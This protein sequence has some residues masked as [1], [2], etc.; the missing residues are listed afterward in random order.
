MFFTLRE[1]R[2][3]WLRLVFRII[4][5]TV[6]ITGL[7]LCLYLESI[8]TMVTEDRE[9]AALFNRL[10]TGNGFLLEEFNAV[11]RN[12]QAVI[13]VL[14]V[15]LCVM[16]YYLIAHEIR[17]RVYIHKLLYCIGYKPVWILTYEFMYELW[18]LFFGVVISLVSFIILRTQI[19]RI[20]KMEEI[21]QELHWNIGE[22]LI[23]FVGVF[24]VLN[25]LDI[26]CC[27]SHMYISRKFR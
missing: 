17:V 10:L 22:D 27:L 18:D 1:K 5:L 13:F 19:M 23:V 8:F 4:V 3:Q 21:F 9:T 6:N 25:I 15:G 16:I 7:F 20:E 2:Q 11:I 24:I 12:I 26:W 14:T